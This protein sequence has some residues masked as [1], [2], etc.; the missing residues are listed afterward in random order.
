MVGN[1]GEPEVAVCDHETAGCMTDYS[2]ESEYDSPGAF[3]E[4]DILLPTYAEDEDSMSNDSVLSD[5]ES[6]A[7]SH[8]FRNCEQVHG[9]P[10]DDEDEDDEGKCMN[11]TSLYHGTFLY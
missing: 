11:T 8:H 4:D 2:D 9:D 7:V 6:D 1:D 3:D 10:D 5:Q